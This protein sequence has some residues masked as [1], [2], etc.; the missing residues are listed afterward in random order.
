MES[1]LTLSLEGHI[2]EKAEEYARQHNTSLAQLVETYLNV[3]ASQQKTEEEITPLVKSLSGM[4]KKEKE[5]N[6]QEAYSRYLSE[7]YK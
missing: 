1:K 3:L 2:L 7:K 5:Y 6:H 4:V